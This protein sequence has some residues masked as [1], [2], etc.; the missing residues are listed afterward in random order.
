VL[1]AVS[2]WAWGGGLPPG[3]LALE[4]GP[5]PA[6]RLANLDGKV[7]D[8]QDLRD[9]WVLV[10]FWATW[11]G[12]CRKEIPAL[13]KMA[14]TLPSEH[15]RLV[16]VDTAELDDE[17]FAFMGLAAPKLDTLMDR[18]GHVTE[19]WQPRGLPSSFLVDPDGRLRYVFLGGRDWTSEAYL[20][21][22]RGLPVGPGPRKT[23]AKEQ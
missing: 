9:Q 20:T 2:S 15:L 6:L 14:Q 21:F 1:L 10:H 13:Q 17:V 7:T 5:A 22:L 19:K 12:P 18:D 23:P 4:G 11:C 16:L 8:L 3:T